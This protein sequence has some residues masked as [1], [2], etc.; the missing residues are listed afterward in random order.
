MSTTPL[1]NTMQS[2]SVK[3]WVHK[4]IN[5]ELT[6]S[7][8]WVICGVAV[9]ALV[10]PRLFPLSVN[11]LYYDDFYPGIPQADLRLHQFGSAAELAFWFW[12]Y[13]PDY[14]RSYVPKL[15]S[16]AYIMTGVWAMTQI[17]RAW[18]VPLATAL[19]AVLLFLINPI[20]TDYLVWNT[21]SPDNIAWAFV[22]LGY[23]AQLKTGRY[24]L[25]VGVALGFLALG[26]YQLV[27]G[28]P[29]M[30]VLTEATL[31]I[32]LNDEN[33]MPWKRRL[34]WLALPIVL[35][36][37]Y[38]SVSQWILDNPLSAA[39]GVRRGLPTLSEALSLPFLLQRYHESSHGYFNVF[40][41]LLSYFF[42]IEAAWRGAWKAWV[43]IALSVPT[44]LLL[45]R[46][47]LRVLVFCSA[48][49]LAALLMPMAFHWGVTLS[50]SGWRAAIGMLLAFSLWF[51]V[52]SMIL[53][54]S[55]LP[56]IAG[57]ANLCA[58]GLVISLVPV[59]VR[60]AENRA[61]GSEATKSLIK[62]L[63]S[64]PTFL[65]TEAVATSIDVKP[66][67]LR[68]QKQSGTI[69]MSF[70][71][72]SCRDYSVAGY[73]NAIEVVLRT[74]GV[75]LVPETSLSTEVRTRTH[76]VV[77]AEPRAAEMWDLWGEG[78]CVKSRRG[79]FL[80]ARPNL[81]VLGLMFKN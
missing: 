36:A 80:L 33:N 64:R 38:L 42:G 32:A 7:A 10:L 72:V 73:Q 3:T 13:G 39:E 43:F 14:L 49:F 31:K 61:Q 17:F 53:L 81:Q 34:V 8:V 52:L 55:K 59:T 63:G 5:R 69:V 44:S 78:L 77:R 12:V 26:T 21:I 74:G 4:I 19:L 29:A 41:P 22:L 27:V 66:D 71:E 28:L 1:S 51:V 2:N 48:L 76:H 20:L 35:Y 75:R 37:G 9:A 11:F 18:N 58:L 62:I 54:K 67:S 65:G 68:Q 47:S 25:A 50:S 46:A 60:D 57:L 24:A 30:L 45:T 23:W 79:L 40:Q 70:Q 6:S 16:L 15:A 56:G